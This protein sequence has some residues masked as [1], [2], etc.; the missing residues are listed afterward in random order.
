MGDPE[1]QPILARLISPLL[2]VLQAAA[3]STLANQTLEWDARV[4]LGVV[5]C[6]EGYPGEV[7][8][9][10]VIAGLDDADDSTLVFHAGTKLQGDAVLTDGGRVLCVVGLG[11]D[12]QAAKAAAYTRAE[13]I[14]WPG[15]FMRPDIGW[16][17]V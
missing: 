11:V 8:K 17:A 12:T 1:T 7:R 6:A 5:L 9:N 14:S 10:D 13:Q 4:A 3:S 2:P 16:R 15:Q